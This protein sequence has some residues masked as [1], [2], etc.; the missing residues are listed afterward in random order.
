MSK[1]KKNLGIAAGDEENIVKSV[2]K[3]DDAIDDKLFYGLLS[4]VASGWTGLN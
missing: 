4:G 1:A 3:E 2:Q